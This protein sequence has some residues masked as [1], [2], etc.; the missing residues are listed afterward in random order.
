MSTTN[1]LTQYAVSGKGDLVSWQGDI[2][3]PGEDT[4][5]RPVTPLVENEVF[6]EEMR[7]LGF[8]RGRSSA[9]FFWATKDDRRFQMFMVDMAETIRLFGIAKARKPAESVKARLWGEEQIIGYCRGRW[10]IVKRGQNYG[11]QP[12]GSE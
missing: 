3:A 2:V 1:N 10:R 7:L 4:Q 11:L 12:V 6:A 5:K 8:G 9:V